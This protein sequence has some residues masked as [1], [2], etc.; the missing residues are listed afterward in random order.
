MKRVYFVRHGE[1]EGNSEKIFKQADAALTERGHKQSQFLAERFNALQPTA[2]LSGPVKRTL[3]TA[4]HF[5]DA[6]GLSVEKYDGF[7][8][9]KFASSM[10]GKSKTGPEALHYFTQIKETYK[11]RDAHFEDAENYTDLHT[12]IKSNM[13]MLASHL[14]DTIVVITHESLIKSILIFVLHQ[15]GYTPLENIDFKNAVSSMSNTGLTSFIYTNN[16]W[17]LETW[18]DHAHF[19]E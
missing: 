6:L 8:P 16:T 10:I 7:G 12:R 13:E 5:N 14:E 18:N 11:N 9:I 19:A 4:Q 3:E 17:Q 1:A 15:G 2:L